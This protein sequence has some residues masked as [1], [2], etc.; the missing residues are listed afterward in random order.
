LFIIQVIFRAEYRDASVTGPTKQG[1]SP[2][3]Y[4]TGNS[5]LELTEDLMGLLIG[6]ATDD[7]GVSGGVDSHKANGDEFA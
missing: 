7:L 1:T 2:I 5:I 4:L 3:F 6:E